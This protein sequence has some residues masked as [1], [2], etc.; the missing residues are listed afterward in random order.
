MHR[1]HAGRVVQLLGNILADALERAATGARRVGGFV[2]E[3]GAWQIRRQRRALGLLL[4]DSLCIGALERFELNADRFQIGVE[5]LIEQ[6]TLLALQ[7]L[8][9]GCE[10][11]ALQDRHLV[12][13]LVDL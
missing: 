8:A 11:P 12:R 13:E 5:R 3:L 10:L 6:V 1:E 4:G 7:L 2:V 9:T